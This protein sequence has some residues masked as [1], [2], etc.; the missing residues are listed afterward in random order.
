MILFYTNFLYV[1]L[2]YQLLSFILFF[3]HFYLLTTILTFGLFLFNWSCL[4]LTL[5]LPNSLIL[6]SKS[7]FIILFVFFLILFNIE[8]V[9]SLSFTL[10]LF[11][12]RNFLFFLF[13]HHQF[14]LFLLLYLLLDFFLF[15]FFFN[16]TLVIYIYRSDF[17]FGKKNLC[18]WWALIRA[19]H[20]V[21][22]FF[23]SFE[24]TLFIVFV[25]FDLNY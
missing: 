17:V 3:S 19:K 5:G 15:Y 11:F 10:V 4:F 18:N 20:V 13:I 23:L 24:M 1:D 2:S 12:F 7:F 22:C 8:Y 9:S 16:L 25:C 14:F 6:A 21:Y